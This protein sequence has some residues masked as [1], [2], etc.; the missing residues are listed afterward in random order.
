VKPLDP[1]NSDAMV[2]W[3]LED[4]EFY[5]DYVVK[6]PFPIQ[7]HEKTPHP[8]A[9]E[10]RILTVLFQKYFEN[11]KC[12]PEWLLRTLE[13]GITKFFPVP[14]SVESSTDD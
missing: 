6:T 1:K 13:P 10:R 3:R 4:N 11:N 2:A 9:Q 8:R 12:K 14:G 7:E 5:L